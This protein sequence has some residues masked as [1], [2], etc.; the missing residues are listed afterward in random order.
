MLTHDD[1]LAW[2]LPGVDGQVEGQAGGQ[3]EHPHHAQTLTHHGSPVWEVP[4]VD[5]QVEEQAGG[6]HEHPTRTDSDT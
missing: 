3:H 1:S 6:K 4:G 2:E 5:G